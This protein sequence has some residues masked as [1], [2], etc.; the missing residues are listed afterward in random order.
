MKK[1]LISLAMLSGFSVQAQAH[2]PNSFQDFVSDREMPAKIS[3][4]YA[5]IEPSKARSKKMIGKLKAYTFP[6]D[7]YSKM[8]DQQKAAINIECGKGEEAYM[9]TDEDNFSVFN[10]DAI[11]KVSIKTGDITVICQ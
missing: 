5:Q 7:S 1:I 11:D 3:R 8:S 10:N 6:T 4:L 9:F 2:I